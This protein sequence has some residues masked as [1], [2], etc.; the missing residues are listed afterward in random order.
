MGVR[1]S[2]THSITY[3]DVRV[4]KDYLLGEKGQGLYQTLE[5]LDGGRISIGALSV[6]LARAA[7][8]DAT[9]Y[10]SER[11]TF[12]K[13][14]TEHQAIQWMIADGA[15]KIEAARLLVFQAAW[16][17][18]VGENYTKEAAMAKL[19][20]SEM[21][22]QVCRDAIQILGS[23]GYSSEYNVERYYRDARLMTIGEGA[24]EIQ[25]MVISKRVINP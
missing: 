4:P 3:E 13:A 9:Q 16:R 20:A 17:K 6:G 19:F 8:E 25:R 12:G 24:S 15:T 21:A 11:H 10:A 1:A 18:Q 14:L 22:E 7:L 5:V 23:Y 2:P